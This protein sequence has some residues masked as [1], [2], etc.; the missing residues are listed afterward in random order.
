MGMFDD[1]IFEKA[2]VNCKCAKEIKNFQT[3]D[4]ENLLTTFKVTKRNKFKKEI[5]RLRKPYKREQYKIGK[6]VLPF[7]VKEHKGWKTLNLTDTIYCCTDCDN[8][9]N[10]WFDIKMIWIK[11]KLDS[12]KIFKTKLR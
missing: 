4:L 6:I 7:M 3:K 12:L 10:W 9:G 2:P 11:G 5:I 1:I 8:C